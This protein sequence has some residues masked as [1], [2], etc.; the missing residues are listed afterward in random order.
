[1]DCYVCACEG[2]EKKAVA[3]CRHCSVALCMKHLAEL[4]THNQGGMRYTCDHSV[5]RPP[6]LA[7]TSRQP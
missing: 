7:A 1:M 5:P 6:K 2:E 4:Q 3:L